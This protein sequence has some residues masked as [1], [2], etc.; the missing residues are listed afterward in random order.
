MTSMTK[1]VTA[2]AVAVLAAGGLAACGKSATPSTGSSTSS[3][4][5]P[6]SKPAGTLRIVAT[7]GPD[8]IDTV[9]AYYTA[10]YM[11]ERAYTR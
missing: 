11:L 4:S 6:P 7:A 8:H 3:A 10:D 2:L 5:T 1:R 9:P